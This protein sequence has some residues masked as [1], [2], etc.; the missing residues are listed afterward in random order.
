MITMIDMNDIR[1]LRLITCVGWRRRRRTAATDL[2]LGH[3]G[4]VLK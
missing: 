2:E 3:L 1:R 4:H